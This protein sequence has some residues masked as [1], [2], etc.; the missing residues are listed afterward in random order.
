MGISIP[1]VSK[2]HS[3]IVIIPRVVFLEPTLKLG[4][5]G[6]V[7]YRQLDLA[8]LRRAADKTVVRGFAHL[9]RIKKIKVLLAREEIGGIWASEP[10]GGRA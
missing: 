2:L 5:I 3:N 6:E 4:K 10:R 9:F 1:I 7:G 8:F